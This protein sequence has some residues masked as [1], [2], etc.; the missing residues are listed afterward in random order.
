[1]NFPM[2]NPAPKRHRRKRRSTAGPAE[3]TLVSAEYNPGTS[4]RLTFNQAIDISAV[5]VAQITVKD[6]VHINV[7]Y[8]GGGTP[9][10]FG[11]NAVDIGLEESGPYAGTEILLTATPLNGI[12]S[13][14]DDEPWAGV[15]DMVVPA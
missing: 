9:V 10:A 6:G 3:L 1:M 4:I 14:D 12:V 8:Q 11:A 2:F 15:T 7:I 5:A 13:A